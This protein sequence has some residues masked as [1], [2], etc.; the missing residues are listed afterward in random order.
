MVHAGNPSRLEC[1]FVS[2]TGLKGS[3]SELIHGESLDRILDDLLSGKL[4]I[5]ND[6][7]TVL[8]DRVSGIVKLRN[9]S[10]APTGT[11][12][13]LGTVLKC[14]VLYSLSFY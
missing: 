6:R 14:Q 8:K 10:N 1:L 12:D 4:L 7:L 2:A 3:S 13:A 11:A 5:A 9:L